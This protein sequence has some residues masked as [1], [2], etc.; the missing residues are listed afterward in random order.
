MCVCVCVC[1]CVCGRTTCAFWA[2]SPLFPP[3]C[4]SAPKAFW[5]FCIV[6]PFLPKAV[7]RQTDRDGRMRRT[8]TLR[9]DTPSPLATATS[10][11]TDRRQMRETTATMRCAA[12][13][14]KVQPN[15]AQPSPAHQKK[16][17]QVERKNNKKNDKNRD[18]KGMMTMKEWTSEQKTKVGLPVNVVFNSMMQWDSDARLSAEPTAKVRAVGEVLDRL[19]VVRLVDR[20]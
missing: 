7:T 3:S 17:H 16:S 4:P 11:L 20:Q 12:S 14:V 13:R 5:G 15:T 10:G 2:A 19:A 9:N 1:V 8:D 6:F 18:K